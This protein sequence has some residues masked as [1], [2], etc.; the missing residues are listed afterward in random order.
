[1]QISIIITEVIAYAITTH[2]FNEAGNI[3]PPEKLSGTHR[4]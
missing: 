2:R 1:M 4:L 3:L